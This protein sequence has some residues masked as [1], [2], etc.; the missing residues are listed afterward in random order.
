MLMECKS[1][2]E[3]VG[4]P[5]AASVI[6]IVLP[7][8]AISAFL[9][10]LLDEW[11][12]YALFHSRSDAIGGEGLIFAIPFAAFFSWLFWQIPRSRMKLRYKGSNCPHCGARNW[13]PPRYSGFKALP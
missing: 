1:C 13:G 11:A 7:A 12:H 5:R 8:T 2:H 4:V 6:K 3:S 10:A 9:C